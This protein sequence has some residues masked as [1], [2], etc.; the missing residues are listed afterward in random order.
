MYNL[1]PIIIILVCLVII[2]FIIIRKFPQLAVLDVANLPEE[3]EDQTKAKII[4]ERLHRDFSFLSK[5]WQKLSR[6]WRL[7][8]GFTFFWLEKLTKIRDEYL[9]SKKMAG[10]S[11][12]E[13]ISL[14]I[15][16]ADE[17]KK[18][19]ELADLNLAESKLIEAVSIDR[20]NLSAF[21]DLAEVY[22]R[23][24]KY[25][26]SKQTYLYCLKLLE[27]NPDKNQEA[28]VNYSLA[29]VNWE[30]RELDEAQENIIESL[31]TLPLSPRFL[32][33][34]ISIDLEMRDLKS[35]S[36]HLQVLEDSNPE[37]NKLAEFRER[38]EKL[39]N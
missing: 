25:L 39:K 9:N 35:A 3:K 36:E 34:A 37:N 19:E 33:L 7:K 20:K 12:A 17:L 10:I 31:N 16:E 32:D 1:L 5:F 26:E 27:L 11:S 13:K 38:I 30:L 28:E 22:F 15:K 21:I 29:E 4:K 24:K 6:F 23:Q 2:L 8:F 14:L 18:S